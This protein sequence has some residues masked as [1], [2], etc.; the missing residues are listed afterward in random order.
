M[1]LDAKGDL[2]PIE[3]DRVDIRVLNPRTRFVA[4]RPVWMEMEGRRIPV[5]IDTADC[6]EN[7]CIVSAFDVS[8]GERAVPYDRV[9]VNTAKVNL[10]LPPDSEIE[11]RGYLRDGTLV[12]KHL[13]K[14]SR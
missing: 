5:V 13:L 2:L 12:F 1:L 4:D 9:E 14:T 11:I 7:A 10:Y 3:R 8:W 6:V